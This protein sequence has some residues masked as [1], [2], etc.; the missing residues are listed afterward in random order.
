MRKVSVDKI[1]NSGL[2]DYQHS[3][4]G[5]SSWWFIDSSFQRRMLTQF[6]QVGI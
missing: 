1:R 4:Q 2:N 6:G 3:K 5:V